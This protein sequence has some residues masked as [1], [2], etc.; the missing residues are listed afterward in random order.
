MTA[1]RVVL[2]LSLAAATSAAAH[3]EPARIPGGWFESPVLLDDERRIAI[4]PFRLDATQ[5]TNAEFGAFIAA[6]PAWSRAAAPAVFRDGRYLAG[7]AG[8]PAAH[9]VTGVSWFAAGAY[10]AWRGGRLPTLDEWEFVAAAGGGGDAYAN[11][12]FSYYADPAASARRPVGAGVP[13][14]LGVH[15]MHGL[16]LEWVE[17][18][19]LVLTDGGGCGDTARFLPEFDPEHYATFLRYQSRSSYSP[20]TTASTLG[21]RC[22]YDL[23]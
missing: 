19:Q 17:D 8:A 14:R 20:R 23:E 11:R 4:R 6:N 1:V 15:D 21:F 12:I 10:C 5:V 2:C 13:N 16:V 9:P 3:A 18:F 7:L 22:A